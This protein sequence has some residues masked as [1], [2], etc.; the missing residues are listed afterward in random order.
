MLEAL[1]AVIT[2]SINPSICFSPCD[3]VATV[4]HEEHPA[5]KEIEMLLECDSGFERRSTLPTPPGSPKTHQIRYPSIPTGNCSLVMR[6][7]RHDAG[8]WEAGR[9]QKEIEVREGEENNKLKKGNRR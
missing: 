4:R 7:I 9:A 5:N 6:L 2:L 1:A 3:V 8:T